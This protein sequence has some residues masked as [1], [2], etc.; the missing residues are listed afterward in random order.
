MKEL[1]ALAGE[2][3]AITDDGFASV[4]AALTGGPPLEEL[5]AL[6]AE[7]DQP[8]RG[9][10]TATVRDG[11]G[12][13]PIRGPLFARANWMT[14]YL[15]FGAYDTIARDFQAATRNPDVRA[16]VL[17]IDSPGGMVT[18]VAELAALIAQARGQGK[19][20]VAFAG[21][22]MA[23]AAYWVGSAADRIVAAPTALLGSIGVRMD[24]VDTSERDARSGVTKRTFVS[25]QSPFK[26]EDHASED[27]RARVQTV[28]DGLAQVFIETVARHRGLDAE[29]VV[30]GYGQGD[31]LV[32]QAARAAGMADALG[33]F[34][35]LAG[36]LAASPPAAGWPGLIAR[37]PTNGDT[38][39]M[40]TIETSAI[41]TD[42]IAANHPDIAAKFRAD[43]AAQGLKDGAKAESERVA[44]IDALALPGCDA[45]VAKA[46]AD[47]GMTAEA[48]AM[49]QAEH[50]KA[51]KSDALKAFQGDEQGFTAPAAAVTSGDGTPSET[52][53]IKALI[54]SVAKA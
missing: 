5:A 16:I 46:K 1:I 2:P 17:D 15:G 53:T 19:P 27:G 3:W 14:R 24:V 41:T 29:A 44:R 10:A 38:P 50:L 39:D 43:G 33:T 49:A 28:V 47:P 8:L 35:S 32:A 22:L 20:I 18:G 6:S 12:V 36:E 34:E 26:A 30:A 54:D 52:D 37:T 42:Y 31:V 51:R 25:R 9:T 40:A 23:S 45:V 13:I 21:G 11:V 48:F 7:P 4:M